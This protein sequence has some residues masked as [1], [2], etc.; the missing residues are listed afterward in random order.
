[1]LYGIVAATTTALLAAALRAPARR[2][3]GP[4]GRE[5][6]GAVTLGPE[7]ARLLLA[8][9]A[10]A[11]LGLVDDVRRL[12]R[13]VLLEVMD[14]I[15]VLMSVPAA[16]LTGFPL[17]DCRGCRCRTRAAVA[18]AGRAARCPRRAGPVV[19]ALS[20]VP[21]YADRSTVLPQVRASLRVRSG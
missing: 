15:A 6:A 14:G 18:A 7:A 19:F 3:R 1:M 4:V 16:A 11:L 12:R 5:R 10:V 20:S 9:G 2:L 8:A 17:R 21:V 13:R